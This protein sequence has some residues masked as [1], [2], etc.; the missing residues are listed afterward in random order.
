VCFV[1][2]DNPPDLTIA[3]ISPVAECGAATGVAPS[4]QAH[5][6]SPPGVRWAAARA[7]SPLPTP[8]SSSHQ[9]STPALRRVPVAIS[10]RLTDRYV[11]AF[12]NE[13]AR[14]AR[15]GQRLRGQAFT[16]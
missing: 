16:S 3:G 10:G 1:G 14:A 13:G 8:R 5:S 11:G 7:A 9:V 2:S 12:G 6:Q 15:E 4:E